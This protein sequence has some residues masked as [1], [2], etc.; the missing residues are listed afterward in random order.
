MSVPAWPDQEVNEMLS[1]QPSGF[2]F[3]RIIFDDNGEISNLKPVEA[4]D[5]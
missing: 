3:H 1:Q 2:H 5:D 4:H